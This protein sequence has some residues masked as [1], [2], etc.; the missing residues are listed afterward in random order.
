MNSPLKRIAWLSPYG[1][2][3][4]IGSFTRNLLPHLSHPQDGKVFDVHVW[5]NDNGPSYSSQVAQLSLAN[6]PNL[7]TLLGLYDFTIFNVGNNVE[8]H[9]HIA[10]A[11]KSHAGVVI[12]HDL[13]Y[14]HFFANE[15][16]EN[17][18]SPAAYARLMGELY[19]KPALETIH[20]SGIC[21]PG[22]AHY[23]PWDSEQVTHYPMFELMTGLASAVVVHSDFAFEAVKRKYKGPV[24][25]LALPYDQ[26][27][28]FSDENI[29]KWQK[30]S[31]HKPRLQFT[32]FGHISRAKLLDKVLLGFAASPYLRDHA[33]LLIAGHPG[34]HGYL[35][36][37]RSMVK[38]LQIQE[39][40]TIELS[41]TDTRL[42]Q[43]KA[44]TDVFVNLRYPNTEAGSGSLVEQLNT[45]R[46]VVVHDSG[47]YADIPDG[48][49]V[50]WRLDSG[51]ESLTAAF[52]GLARDAR[53]RAVV[54]QAGRSYVQ[55]IGGEEYARQL[56]SFLLE[57]QGS[58]HAVQAA[59]GDRS[60]VLPAQVVAGE[61]V[62]QIQE[63]RD[64]WSLLEVDAYCYSPRP[65]L[66]WRPDAAAA[67]AAV[68]VMPRK[69][70][71][72]QAL[73]ERRLADDP[74]S[75]YE[76]LCKLRTGLRIADAW[77]S[78]AADAPYGT[79]VFSPSFWEVA[80][81]LQPA[82]LVKLCFV[83]LAGKIWN[84]P[85]SPVWTEVLESKLPPTLMLWSFLQSDHLD[86]QPTEERL[87]LAQWAL[88][89]PAR[90]AQAQRVCRFL[91][92]RGVLALTG[93]NAQS[94]ILE[95]D[96]FDEQ[97]YLGRH[98]DVAAAVA[99]GMFESGFDHF[100]R[101]GRK[102]G[103]SFMLRPIPLEELAPHSFA[104]GWS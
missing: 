45:G 39:Q 47:C 82:D 48:A 18:K 80:L 73:A 89:E 26:K 10:G 56:K 76:N 17:K 37:L 90:L 7:R 64:L 49:A 79:L 100:V 92:S 9:L 25:R 31:E 72:F 83:Y 28:M 98:P 3:S 30:A 42:L 21:L 59:L 104:G 77:E 66:R 8:N 5:V 65:F 53:L 35:E 19:G 36:D 16:F 52:E 38:S 43:I 96:D 99:R 24:L 27:S 1:P 41:V 4:D 11:L 55:R 12:F 86:T 60:A 70:P 29:E 50:K 51:L 46:P 74:I 94:A 40:V 13:V 75:F 2:R 103:R 23:A 87:Q 84:A 32:S 71:A 22:H 69:R 95:Q 102:E 6:Q 81:L 61:I 33:R 15:C 88:G 93:A 20:H 68:L 62:G 85:L 97:D 54:G 34:D 67:L 57:T 78:G 44:E 91:Q 101:N 63:T 58:L 14:Q